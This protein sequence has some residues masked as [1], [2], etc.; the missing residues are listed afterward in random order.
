MLRLPLVATVGHPLRFSVA[1]KHHGLAMWTGWPPKPTKLS[2]RNEDKNNVLFETWA[3][4][5]YKMDSDESFYPTLIELLKSVNVPKHLYDRDMPAPSMNNDAA[6]E[7]LFNND[8]EEA[9]IGAEL[10]LVADGDI[11]DNQDDDD[12]SKPATKAKG[13]AKAKSKPKL[14]AKPTSK[15]DG[16]AIEPAAVFEEEVQGSFEGVQS[17]GDSM[18]IAGGGEYTMSGALSDTQAAGTG[19]ELPSGNIEAMDFS[20]DA[21]APAPDSMTGKSLLVPG[22]HILTK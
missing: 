9:L 19:D 22:M 5:L 17:V 11:G 13:R 14:M 12:D 10:D 2:D 18:D 21:P 3:S 20:S 16:K 7:Q 4:N 6:E 1:H 15:K 8:V